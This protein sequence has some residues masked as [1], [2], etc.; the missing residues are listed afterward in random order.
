VRRSDQR[1]DAVFALY[2]H[3]VTGRPLGDLLEE[4]KPFSRELAEA[5]EANRP[6]L[7]ALISTHSKG[8]AIER[9]APL[10]RNILRTALYEARHV[11]DVPVEVAIDE[12]VE[13][14]KQYC[15]ADA[16]GFVNGILGAA[17]E[18]RGAVD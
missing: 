2:Q 12:A 5:V 6:E 10:E 3:D 14:A 8:W 11:D 15:G 17:L 13:L 16:P 4:A 9:I 18:E 1:R 7:D